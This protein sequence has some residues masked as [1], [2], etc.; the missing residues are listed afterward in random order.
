MCLILDTS[1]TASSDTSVSSLGASLCPHLPGS[2]WGG[3]VCL[4]GH[5]DGLGKARG[6]ILPGLSDGK[7]PGWQ[8]SLSLGIHSGHSFLYIFRSNFLSRNICILGL[9]S[10][11]SDQFVWFWEHAVYPVVEDGFVC[12]SIRGLIL[13][14]DQTVGFRALVE[15]TPDLQPHL[16]DLCQIYRL[17]DHLG[18]ILQEVGSGIHGLHQLSLTFPR[19]PPFSTSL[20]QSHHEHRKISRQILPE[21]RRLAKSLHLIP[22]AIW[23]ISRIQYRM[24]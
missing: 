15:H 13:N 8:L 24:E 12:M 14:K 20:I 3:G 19:T 6:S 11:Q 2:R 21:L 10:D 17:V 16:I 22:I 7:V 4:L 1:R 5:L 9:L 23:K 18:N